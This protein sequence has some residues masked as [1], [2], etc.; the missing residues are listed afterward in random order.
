MGERRGRCRVPEP[1]RACSRGPSRAPRRS[2]GPW[3]AFSGAR[4]EA[5]RPHASVTTRRPATEAAS[6]TMPQSLIERSVSTTMPHSACSSGRPRTHRYTPASGS[7]GASGPQTPRPMSPHRAS[8]CADSASSRRAIRSFD[9]R[10]SPSTYRASARSPPASASSSWPTSDPSERPTSS[11]AATASPHR[12]WGDTVGY[13]SV[14]AAGAFIMRLDEQMA[15]FDAAHPSRLAGPPLR[16][17]CALSPCTRADRIVPA[18]AAA[19][20]S[21]SQD[22]TVKQVPRRHSSHVTSFSTTSRRRPSAA[23]APKKP[24][25]FVSASSS[26]R[27]TQPSGPRRAA[28]RP[29]RRPGSSRAPARSAQA[30]QGPRPRR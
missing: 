7:N 1:R 25:P 9:S 8:E 21:R 20:S 6:L 10:P 17:T 27:A 15:A 5:G 19:V 4:T 2:R 26:P 13:E 18:P 28:A 22:S 3:S 11:A 30:A 14:A 16:R 29:P 23:A 12:M 24:G